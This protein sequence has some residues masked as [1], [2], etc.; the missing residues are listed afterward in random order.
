MTKLNNELA[1]LALGDLDEVV[2]GGKIGDAA[3]QTSLFKAA[4]DIGQA[5]TQQTLPGIGNLLAD[6]KQH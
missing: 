5:A 1:A 3:H 4:S 2:G 6:I